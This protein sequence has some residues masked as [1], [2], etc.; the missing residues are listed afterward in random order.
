MNETAPAPGVEPLTAFASP[1]TL[2]LDEERTSG[3]G[4]EEALFLSFT[5]DLGFFEDVALGVTQ[6]T[7]ARITVA[8]D[9]SM[10]RNDPRSVR[11]AG[12]SYLAGLAYAHGA[13]FHPKLMVLAGPDHATIA[14]G[15]GNTTLA[16]WQ[17]NAELWT[18]LRVDGD[19]SPPAIPDLAAWLRDLPE[20]VR[21]SA[22]V[23]QALGR[24]A[25]LLD[26]LHRN[27][28]PTEPQVR[29]VSSLRSPIIDQL[30]HGPVDELAVFAPFYDQRSIALRQLLERFRPSRFTLAY[31]PGLSDLDGPSVAALVKEYDG[32][33]I[34]D[35]DQRYRHGKLVE[36]ASGGQRW[37]LTGSPNL[38]AAA[39]LLSQGEGGNCELGVIAPITSTLLPVGTEEP[40]ARL[41]TAVPL[42]R[43]TAGSGPLLLG[44]IRVSEGL[45][46]SMARPL[47]DTAHLELSQAAAPPEA[48]ERIA[49]I[50]HG[51]ATLT[52]TAPADAGSR[53]RLV[54]VDSDGVPSFGNIVFVVDP[55]RALRRMVPAESQAPTTQPAELFTDPKLAERILG[56]LETLRTG[57]IPVPAGAPASRGS[58]GMTATAPL[59]GDEDGWERYLD[60]CAGRLGH[61]LTS[62]ALGLPLPTGT[63]TLFQDLLPVSWD[64]RFTDD[65][66]AALDEDDAEAVAAEHAPEAVGTET[67]TAT[68][69]DL[70]QADQEVRRRYRRLVERLVAFALAPAR[71]PVERM[72]VVRLT[73]WFV[74]AGAWSPTYTG[75]V[76]LLSRA[77]RAMGE[78]V[79]ERVES[80]VGSLAA[81]ALA[82]LRSHAPRYE[83]TPETLAFNEASQAVGHLLPAVDSAYVTEYTVLLDTAFGPSVDQAAVLDVAS[84]VV[85]DDP[86]AD[87]VWSL[88]EKGRDV[89]RHGQLL[90]HITGRFSNPALVALE[91]VGAAEDAPLVGAWANSG[92]DSSGGAWALVVWRRPDLIVVDAR[93][94]IPLWRHYRLIGLVGPRALAAQRSFES[95]ASVPHGPRNQP[96]ELA[97]QVLSDL[98][99]AGPR[100]PQ[101]GP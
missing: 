57:L 5:A 94:P 79:P 9:V 28:T 10:A 59:D 15:S 64:E 80:Q 38:S 62:F 47:S 19:Q 89:H 97:H 49:D 85:Q 86:L 7:G 92:S 67:D 23:P 53:A 71:G 52:V 44:A 56:D 34:S 42:P 65:I 51:Q 26:R 55:V 83:I 72:L 29:V 37:A 82:V 35:N 48:W 20:R 77:V 13:A 76:P 22:G 100:P 60:E 32:R 101:C 70:R 33:V 14:L 81:V 95:A 46:I 45:E 43:P 12:R 41:R 27:R 31:Q 8:G 99:L 75:W 16:G 2:I 11:R 58:D 40:A 54:V 78:R 30:P 24:V 25:A 1:L 90:L 96:F 69:P 3:H 68:L 88:T 36:W 73:L 39:L 63:D 21:F 98:R 91:A 61:P 74:A 18:V 87:A 17:A 66:E 50:P 84:D 6:A 93:R 4:L